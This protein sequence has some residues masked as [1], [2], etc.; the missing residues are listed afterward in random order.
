MPYLIFTQTKTFQIFHPYHPSYRWEN[1]SKQPAT[2]QHLV[3][4]RVRSWSQR[5]WC[6]VVSY[7]SLCSLLT[8]LLKSGC[9]K[10]MAFSRSKLA[11]RGEVW[12]GGDYDILS[13]NSNSHLCWWDWRWKFP[14]L[15][16]I[17]LDTRNSTSL[18][19]IETGW[20][21]WGKWSTGHE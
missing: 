4:G 18:C 1:S 3:S 21:G 6:S 5:P 9:A 19:W 13:L 11:V 14:A 10:A 12:W 7:G 20:M 16:F 2:G 15:F 8:A 17:F